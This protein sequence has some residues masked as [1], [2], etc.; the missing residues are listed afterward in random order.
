[1]LKAALIGLGG[2]TVSHRK[3]FAELKKMGKAEL[4]AAYDINPEAITKKKAINI[5]SDSGA[6]DS[7]NFYTDLDKML[8]SEKIDFVLVCVPTYLHSEVTVDLLNRGYNV[9]CEKPM[10][11][12]SKDCKKMIDAANKNG[13]KLMI[14]QCLR[15]LEAHDYIKSAIDDG[16]FGKLLSA[17]F[18]RL[19]SPPTWG[20]E[21]WF[22]N[23]SLSGGCITDLHIHDID[24]IRYLLGEPKAVSCRANT[25][26]CVNDTVH[27]T[28]I[29]D[30]IPVTAI[31]DW[32]LKGVKFQANSRFNF[33]K[34]T[35]EC[36]NGSKELT[37]YPK[38]GGEVEKIELSKD[39][40]YFGELSYFCDF[41]EGKIENTK[42]PPESA[43][44]TLRLIEALRKSAGH[45]GKFIKF[46][47]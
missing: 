36:L 17:Y 22:M 43:M 3:A 12:N 4:V 46:S 27:S 42:N 23:P 21:N 44:K 47:V 10:A 25:S 32:T 26:I 41:I 35:V 8:E 1:M 24:L 19:S 16:R 37:V 11:L 20:Y 7:F 9:L 33:E 6:D 30:D 18:E 2:I 15:F 40:A 34:A 13:K 31:G 28:L 14:G 45:G 29:Y 39:S 5:D 38:D